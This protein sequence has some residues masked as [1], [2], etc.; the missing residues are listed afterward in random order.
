M[1]DLVIRIRAKPEANSELAAL[2]TTR[3]DVIEVLP[4]PW[5]FSVIELTNPDWRILRL[6]NVS[7]ADAL[8]LTKP[9]LLTDAGGVD[10]LRRKRSAFFD[11]D[12]ATLPTAIS[13]WLLDDLR[14]VPIFT[15]NINRAQFLKFVK[16]KT[17]RTAAF[18]T[19]T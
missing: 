10:R 14:A 5:A 19:F 13:T 6:P 1:A 18:T 3:G 17:P 7:V 8:V 2:K 15:S 11:V 16:T 12:D 4:T 9:E